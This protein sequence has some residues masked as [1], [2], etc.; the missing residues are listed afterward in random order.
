MDGELDDDLI[1][2]YCGLDQLKWAKNE[3]A[4][5]MTNGLVQEK[6]TAASITG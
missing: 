1:Y 2:V 5:N 3:R 6:Q 4:R